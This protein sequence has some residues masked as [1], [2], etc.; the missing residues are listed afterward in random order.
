MET[1]SELKSNQMTNPDNTAILGCG[2]QKRDL[3][4]D[5]GPIP[6]SQLYTSAY[7][8]LKREYAQTCC[9]NYRVL[10]AK[11]GLIRPDHPVTD[12]YDLSITD[13][14]DV[15]RAEWISEVETD[16]R[17]LADS[18][19]ADTLVVLAGQP[20]LS[21]LNN[22]VHTLP[23]HLRNEVS[24]VVDGMAQDACQIYQTHTDND[25]F[26]SESLVNEK[27]HSTKDGDSV[28]LPNQVTFPTS[29][30]DRRE[31]L[32][33]CDP[34]EPAD[35]PIIVA[36]S[37]MLTG[38]HSPRYLTEM[39]SRYEGASVLLAGYQ[40]NGTGG[41]RLTNGIEAGESE[42]TLEF[43]TH[44]FGTDW[45]HSDRVTQSHSEEEGRITRVRVPLDW[46]DTIDGLSAH[47]SQMGLL[48]F[49]RN[50]SPETITLIHGPAYA[51]QDL[52]NHFI[53][54]VESAHQVARARLLTPVEVTTDPTL[55]TSALTSEMVDNPGHIEFEDRLDNLTQSVGV[56]NR[57][58]AETKQ[59][60]ITDRDEI[61]AI[62]REELI[63]AGLIESN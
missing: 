32:D 46:V 14:S 12:G 19:P 57:I 47:T 30:A 29:D 15:E 48:S 61:R 17:H 39:V 60:A 44:S 36:P 38:G 7:F 23:T 63:E 1:H 28:I 20:Y 42:V 4:G 58:L 54:N 50:V 21:P 56:T 6:I 9:D 33:H 55:E 35:V 13:L 11:H 24:I 18:R 3:S 25:A 59:E 31:I 27:Q 45:P 40:A 62:V 43:D 53:D 26:V 22:R 52:G 34:T 8:K 2:S 41:N 51:Q 49:A 5:T 10:S 37:G 16:L